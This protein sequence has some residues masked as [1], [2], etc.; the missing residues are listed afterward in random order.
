[1]RKF[2]QMGLAIA[3]AAMAVPASSL[4]GEPTFPPTYYTAPAAAAPVAA[5][6][7]THN[8][9]STAQAGTR[10]RI[11]PTK[12]KSPEQQRQELMAKGI[13]VPPVP[14]SIPNGTVIA[15]NGMGIAG[16]ATCQE[17]ATY[18]MSS[19]VSGGMMVASGEVPGRAVVGGG[20]MTASAA[21]EPTPIG[22]VRTNYSP[23]SASAMAEAPG[24][25][26]VGAGSVPA[27]NQMGHEFA[28]S[29]YGKPRSPHVL[30]HMLGIPTLT[31]LREHRA[32]RADSEKAREMHA[33]Q[34]LGA[35]A[36]GPVNALPPS[37]VYGPGPR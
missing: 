13:Y 27:P 33:R 25:A 32:R 3:A 26:V 17:N 2:A 23:N 22:V 10:F 21:G 15:D 8:H 29:G 16:C 9:G 20:M 5:A 24:R 14:S 12:S 4:A 34:A 36:D 35:P 7:T 28:P 31:E 30:Q 11:L 19:P 6:D 18:A 1:M 37:M